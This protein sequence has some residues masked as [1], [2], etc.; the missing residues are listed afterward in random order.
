MPPLAETPE[1]VFFPDGSPAEASDACGEPQR[2][3]VGWR[4]TVS[5]TGPRE[6]WLQAIDPAAGDPSGKK[7]SGRCGFV[8]LLE[9][10]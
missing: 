10:I 9:V 7:G 3:P 2:G 8:L 1:T 4:I 5:P 6:G